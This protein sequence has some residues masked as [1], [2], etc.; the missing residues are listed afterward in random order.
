MVQIELLY[1]NGYQ[2]GKLDKKGSRSRICR[3]GV[4]QSSKIQATIET[5]SRENGVKQKKH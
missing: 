4:W 5:N 3:A 1:M 2:K